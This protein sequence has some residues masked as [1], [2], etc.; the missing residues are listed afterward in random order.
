MS[1]YI[2][3]T[4]FAVKDTY[5]SGDPRKVAKGADVDTEFNNIATSIATKEDAANKGVSNGFAPLDGSALLPV[6]NLP[7][8]VPQYGVANVFTLVASFTGNTYP[9]ALQAA[10]GGWLGIEDTSGGTDAK[11]WDLGGSTSSFLLRYLNDAG[12]TIKNVLEVDRSGDTISAVKFGNATDNP[13]FSFL[14]SGTVSA[15]AFSGNGANLSSLN[16]SNINAGSI[17]ASYVPSG[18]VTQYASSM[19]CRNLPSKGGT[20]VTLQAGGSPSGGSDGDIFYIY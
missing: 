3:T 11:R 10:G 9:V 1:N 4:D 5:S 2:K 6:A 14:G 16:A 13:S 8:T 15:N 7:T 17:G 12:T 18:A 20:N 19:K